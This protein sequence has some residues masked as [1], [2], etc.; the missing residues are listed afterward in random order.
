MPTKKTVKRKKQKTKF[1]YFF[2]NKKAEGNAG[3]KDIL[4]GKGANLAEMTN[5]G[6]PVPPG[7][8][9]SAEVCK[10]F[11]QSKKQWP[12]GLEKQIKENLKKIEKAS[13][14][15]FGNLSNP[16]LLS[17]RSGAA[18]SMPGMMDT[19][20]NIGLNEKSLDTVNKR[21]G[22]LNENFYL[23]QWFDVRCFGGAAFRS[24]SLLYNR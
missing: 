18:V 15:K 16:L 23:S 12:K 3:M 22:E 13:G 24:L 1:V 14:K 4:G 2:G 21:I 7:F 9:I 6:L 11:F 20:L 5:L 10:L 19:V 17:V 8:T